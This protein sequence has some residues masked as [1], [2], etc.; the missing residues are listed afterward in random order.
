MFFFGDFSDLPLENVSKNGI[1]IAKEDH[2]RRTGSEEDH[3]LDSV[4]VS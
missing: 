4:V 1:G 2:R 3:D